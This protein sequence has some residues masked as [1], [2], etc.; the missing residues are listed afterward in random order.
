[1]MHL[2]KQIKTSLKT[3]LQEDIGRVD[4]TTLFTVP[5]HFK[6]K[7]V[8]L[9][10]ENGILCGIDIA[11][12]VFLEKSKNIVF[13][14][15]YKDGDA[16][17]KGEKIA[18]ILG[19][20]RV[21]LSCERVALNFLSLLS[22]IA[23]NTQEFVKR[24]KGTPTKILDTRKTT[25]NLR[26]LEKY[27]V[28]TGGGYNHRTN[29]QEAI[30]IKDNHLRAGKFIRKGIFDEVRMA[31]CISYLRTLAGIKLEIEVESL[32]EFKGVVKYAP[33]IIMLDNF[34]LA[35]LKKAVLFRNKHYPI[36]KLEAS[37]GINL[38]NISAVAKTGVDFIS[39]GS[40]T[41]SPKAIDFS[42]EVL[43]G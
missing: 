41:H 27:A 6:V 24:V 15:F 39:I 26:T 5:Y 33:D 43:D 36:V 32:S 10:K 9:A 23:T 18:F 25:P 17:K 29:L 34:P 12:R 16:F 8:I 30:L 7:S 14:A 42:L 31:K 13:K 22:G 40:I 38:T 28:R 35:N 37:G 21:I 3:A 20:A 4:I 1:M 2:N 11:R 19:D